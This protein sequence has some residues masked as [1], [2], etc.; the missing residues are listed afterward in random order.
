MSNQ[1]TIFGK[2]SAA[3]GQPLP[4]EVHKSR[5]GYYLGTWSD[6]GPFTRES[7]EYWR[8][9]DKAAEAL[10]TGRWTQRPNL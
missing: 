7:A 6:D 3:A 9:Q 4:L 10:K 2:L 8:T 5:A 1:T